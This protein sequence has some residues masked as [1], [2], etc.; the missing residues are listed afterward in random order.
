MLE[1][2]QRAERLGHPLGRHVDRRDEDVEVLGVE[3]HDQEDQRDPDVE[4]QEHGLQDEQRGLGQAAEQLA[5][6]DRD[7]GARLVGQVARRRGGAAEGEQR[8]DHVE[9]QEEDQPGAA[10]V[11]AVE[12]RGA[13]A[14]LGGLLDTHDGEGDDREQHH[15]GDEVL[16]EAQDRRAPDQRDSEVLHEQRAVGLDV[17]RQQDDEAPHGEQVGDAGDRPAQ[18]LALTEDL[19]D[20]RPHA[21][22]QP[23]GTLGVGLTR[24]DQGVQPPRPAGGHGQHHHGQGETQDQS[25]DH[26]G[27]S[28]SS[29]GPNAHRVTNTVG[30][31]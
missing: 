11:R 13:G 12:A 21:R 16:D 6:A 14:P 4:Q 30:A 28:P 9:D 26:C 7:V 19:H 31:L 18:Q 1:G 27:T 25:D 24:G 5:D 8:P 29:R 3:H 22:A 2:L 20:L 17:D 15:D 10:G 23:V